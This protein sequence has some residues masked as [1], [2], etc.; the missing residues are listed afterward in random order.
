MILQ[1][2]T[3]IAGIYAERL[4]S[5]VMYVFFLYISR[6]SVYVEKALYTHFWIC[7]FTV[8]KICK[9][10]PREMLRLKI[11]SDYTYINGSTWLFNYFIK[12]LISFV[13]RMIMQPNILSLLF[14]V[15]YWPSKSWIRFDLFHTICDRSNHS[16]S[17]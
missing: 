12:K 16:R 13:S 3:K 4:M 6:S 17:G 10:V 11:F 1:V 8:E 14:P 9:S 7:L 2:V 5:D 15:L